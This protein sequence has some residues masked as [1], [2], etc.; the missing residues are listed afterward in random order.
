MT[1]PAYPES[2]ANKVKT[3]DQ[4]KTYLAAGKLHG[5]AGQWWHV[6]IYLPVGEVHWKY[7]T[8]LCLVSTY[9][10]DQSNGSERKISTY[11]FSGNQ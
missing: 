9:A 3:S 8:N 5:V 6:D 7:Q 11:G 1:S 10:T 4:G 2:V